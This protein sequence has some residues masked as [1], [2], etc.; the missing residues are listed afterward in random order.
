MSIGHPDWLRGIELDDHPFVAA[1]AF[2][3]SGVELFPFL[4]EP[5]H[6]YQSYQLQLQFLNG[7]ATATN[8]AN[9]V[10]RFYD[11]SGVHTTAHVLWEDEIEINVGGILT[12]ITDRMHGADMSLT[13]IF[14]GGTLGVLWLMSNRPADRLHILEGPTSRSRVLLSRVG[15]LVGAGATSGHLFA[16]LFNGPADI[17][18]DASAA[19]NGFWN[20]FFGNDPN[21]LL[22][23]P[24]TAAA[25]SQ[26]II[27]PN[28]P[29]HFTVQNTSAAAAMYFTSL[30]TRDN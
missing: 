17:S 7:A 25:L 24:F 11:N 1:S 13:P 14:P 19:V 12:F 8:Y 20:I 5:A 6:K 26:E 2:M 3:T 30:W 4:G 27:L 28:K 9:L 10:V 15:V 21:I 18:L 29:M 22:K 16:P 23:I